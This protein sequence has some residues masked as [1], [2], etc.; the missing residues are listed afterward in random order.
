MV[1]FGGQWQAFLRLALGFSPC[2]LGTKPVNIQ[3]GFWEAPPPP[4]PHHPALS[5]LFPVEFQASPGSVL[6]SFCMLAWGSSPSFMGLQ[7]S[8]EG[9][10]RMDS[11]WVAV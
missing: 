4:A 2:D 1:L 8:L 9:Q 10:G 7:P 6:D 3:Q 5:P 11:V